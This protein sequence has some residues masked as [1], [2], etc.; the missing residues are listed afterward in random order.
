MQN[1]NA[2][3]ED[4]GPSTYVRIIVMYL[5]IVMILA[6]FAKIISVQG[7]VHVMNIAKKT[8]TVTMHIAIA[9]TWILTSVDQAV[10]KLVTVY[11]SLMIPDVHPPVLA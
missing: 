8:L 10:D 6:M 2:G 1:V 4:V 3:M 9:V 5:Q 7:Q 11:L